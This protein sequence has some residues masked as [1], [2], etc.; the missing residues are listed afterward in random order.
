[1]TAGGSS[2]VKVRLGRIALYS[3]IPLTW[4]HA[5]REACDLAVDELWKTLPARDALL[6]T[7]QRRPD[8]FAEPPSTLLREQYELVRF[9]HRDAEMAAF[10]A[11]AG[12]RSPNVRIALL[13]GGP[14]RGKTRFARQLCRNVLTW[15]D[16]WLVGFLSADGVSDAEHFAPLMSRTKGPLLLVVDYA[17]RAE[18]VAMTK[19]LVRAALDAAERRGEHQTRILLLARSEGDWYDELETAFE[20]DHR[21]PNPFDRAALK[22]ALEPIARPAG[23]DLQA[24][25]DRAYAAFRALMGQ[26]DG[27][28][29]RVQDWLPEVEQADALDLHM[30]ALLAAFG[31]TPPDLRTD[32][33]PEVALIEKLLKRER[34]RF[35]D[36][37]VE[38]AGLDGQGLKGAVMERIVAWAS[39]VAANADRPTLA[40]RLSHWPGLRGEGQMRTCEGLAGALARLY[41]GAE[42]KTFAGLAPD[43]LATFLTRRL[44]VGDLATAVPGLPQDALGGLL[45]HLTWHAQ[46]YDKTNA[47][48]EREPEREAG[49]ERTSDE[50]TSGCETDRKIETAL[51]AGG[52]E[53]LLA[54][55]GVAMAQGDPAGPLGAKVLARTQDAA[56]SRAIHDATPHDTVNLREL[57]AAATQILRDRAEDPERRAGYANNLA[58]RLGALGR[59]EDALAA[60][61]EAVALRRRLAEARPD[62]FTPDLAASLNNLASFL[63]ALG[64]R[65]DALAAAEEAVAL[66]RAL[67]E[68]R[69]DAFTPDLAMSL[70]NL[71]NRLSALGRREDALEAAEEAAGLYRR[72][73]ADRPDAFAPDLAGS[74]NNLAS[75]LS[76]L[77]R[78]EDALA[79]AEEAVALRR[80]L[81][82]ARPDA[83]TPDLAMSLTNLAIRLSALGRREDALE[84]AEEAVDLYRALAAARPDAFTPDLA[85]SLNN[86]A[87]F[88]SALGRR[89]DALEAAE[90]AVDLYRALAAARPDAFAPNL[91]ASLNNLAN[92]L[93]ALGRREDALAAAE[94]AAD[95]YR[96]LAADR[97]DAFAPDLATSLGARGKVLEGLGRTEDASNSFREG[98]EALSPQFL[99]LPRAYAS[100]VAALAQAYLDSCKQ[101]GRDPDVALLGPIVETFQKLQ[102]QQDDDE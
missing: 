93:G 4:S 16:P 44:Q 96:R 58:V 37:A 21:Q 69:P 102:A 49:C 42:A 24:E 46:R 87:S 99:R 48:P 28:A 73:A 43:R 39:T 63:S 97:P 74:L 36:A 14:G 53:A 2:E 31:D 41:P 30:A 101:V 78:R 57:A 19:A 6:D 79:A 62:A 85:G 68:A 47:I 100:L 10:E 40:A 17:E 90:E 32:E 67:A 75:F 84:A 23:A 20:S 72:L 45:R 89:E 27:A 94:E 92:V 70:T 50:R 55:F 65:E 33:P 25:L 59:R 1:M 15:N 86:L 56:A 29:P 54:A 88:L 35:W 61:E 81:A 83:F 38:T 7:P 12:E 52:T 5:V 91:A 51:A 76:A 3:F 64:R 34:T 80:A 18:R 95:L 66:R 8:P 82:E 77:G 71:A 98:L 13:T 26:A 60:A 9:A 11:W 22:W